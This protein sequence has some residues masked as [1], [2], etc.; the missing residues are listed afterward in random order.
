ME[1]PS[2]DLIRA[3]IGY[4]PCSGTFTR[5]TSKGRARAGDRVGGVGRNGYVYVSVAGEKHLG[6]QVAWVCTHGVWPK[7]RINLK[8]GVRNDVRLDN[9]VEVFKSDPDAE[10]SHERLLSLLDYDRDTG[11]FRWRVFKGS[12]TV[13]REFAGCATARG[14]YSSIRV[15]QKSIMAHRLA[16]FYV[17]GRWPDGE[18]DHID[19][20]GRNNR[21]SNLRDV[22]HETNMQNIRGKTARNKSGSLMG[23]SIGKAGNITSSITVS[24]RGIYLGTFAS[25]TEAHLAYIAAKRAMHKG[26]TI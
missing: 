3:T 19:G 24:G 14:R 11:V 12:P 9:L 17:Y 1:K 15:D 10:L 5:L 7:G 23:V 13:G 2:P 8:N 18:I 21:I 20:D 25:E 26:C 4:D 16:W 6:Q 22:S